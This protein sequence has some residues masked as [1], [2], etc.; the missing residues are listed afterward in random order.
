MKSSIKYVG[1]KSKD[2]KYFKSLIPEFDLYIEPF[3]GGGS[4]FFDLK[5]K[6]SI[7]NDHDFLLMSYWKSVQ[8]NPE[9]LIDKIS[10]YANLTDKTSYYQIRKLYN[11]NQLRHI[12]AFYFYINRIGYHGLI[13]YNKNLKINTPYGQS[14]QFDKYY[15]TIRQ[16]HN[17]LKNSII[18]CKD[19]KDFLTDL[20]NLNILDNES[21][22]F[23]DPP[24][25]NT[26]N[27]L[28][29]DDSEI[30]SLYEY[31]SNY[32]EL[33]KCKVMI[34]T[35]DGDI[36][37]SLFHNKIIKSYNK[38]YTINSGARKRNDIVIITNY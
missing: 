34:L 35:E 23:I 21:F 28:L 37:R 14:V 10:K 2:L 6:H 17:C 25:I 26:Y 22:M 8:K 3:F 36:V 27:Y 31:L 13:R 1:G 33:T 4:V 7:I 15:D 11:E 32:I 19:Y 30:V 29:R 9:V 20:E 18:H 12:D 24:Y 38:K 16:N 5:P